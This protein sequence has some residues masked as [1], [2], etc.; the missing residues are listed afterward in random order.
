[1]KVKNIFT[2]IKSKALSK[3][4]NKM[5]AKIGNIIVHYFKIAFGL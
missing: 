2:L 3:A 1:M 5:S 4:I